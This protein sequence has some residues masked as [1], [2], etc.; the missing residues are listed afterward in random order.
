LFHITVDVDILTISDMSAKKIVIIGAGA[1]GISAATYLYKAG[2]E[3]LV[4]LE[5][6]SRI[7][8]R[9]NTVAFGENVV[10][11]GAQW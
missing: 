3:N 1:A 5:A 4:V 9:I 2:F 6:E 11:M 7:G 10:D 8:G